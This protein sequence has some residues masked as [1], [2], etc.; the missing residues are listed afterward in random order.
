MLQSGNLASCQDLKVLDLW[1]N[2]SVLLDREDVYAYLLQEACCYAQEGAS[3]DTIYHSAEQAQARLNLSIPEGESVL[4]LKHYDAFVK[5]TKRNH[6]S[7]IGSQLSI[8]MEHAKE[9]PLRLTLRDR[10]P[11]NF[12]H[13]IANIGR[14]RWLASPY[15]D[16]KALR[17]ILPSCL[18][19]RGS[20]RYGGIYI[21]QD[22]F[23]DLVQV[24]GIRY[25]TQDLIEAK[26][27]SLW[28]Y[29]YKRW[30]VIAQNEVSSLVLVERGTAT[31]FQSAKVGAQII[32]DLATE[33]SP[34][35]LLN[36][37][38]TGELHDSCNGSVSTP[39]EEPGFKLRRTGHSTPNS[40][41]TVE[42]IND[43]K[44]DRRQLKGCLFH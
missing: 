7:N 34:G 33:H 22:A 37:T 28:Q 26:D 15:V 30:Y 35:T 10:V 16:L 4:T 8:A 38:R 42:W 41:R 1:D 18:E 20:Q 40:S 12:Q 36:P 19:L 14:I 5:H 11:Y 44:K 24:F 3:V 9:S 25:R 13:G 32:L 31:A 27:K 29:T 43:L 39:S 21:P 23:A 6:K 17:Q 2:S